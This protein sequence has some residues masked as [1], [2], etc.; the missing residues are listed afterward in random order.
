MMTGSWNHIYATLSHVWSGKNECRIQI[1][2]NEEKF[3]LNMLNNR[4]VYGFS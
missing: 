1:T 2:K 3:G 4:F